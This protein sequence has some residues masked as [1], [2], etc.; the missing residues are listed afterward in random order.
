ME[1]IAEQIV[2][3]LELG[4]ERYGHGVI[5]NSDTREWGTPNNSWI[6]MATEEF[7]DAIIY[8]IADY[9]GEKTRGGRH[10]KLI[11]NLMR[12]LDRKTRTV[13]GRELASC[14]LKTIINSSYTFLKIIKRLTAP[15]IIRS[16][17]IYLTYYL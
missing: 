1:T 15:S 11:I 10:L 8:V 16:S 5:V 3:R 7:L 9:K 17:G 4:K 12:N 2:G 6:E 13:S 14:A